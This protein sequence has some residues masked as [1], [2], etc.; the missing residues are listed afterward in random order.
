MIALADCNNFYASC[1][2]SIRPELEGKPIVVLSNN[3]GC[4]IAR[5]NESK[6]LGYKMGAPYFKVREQLLRDQ[7]HV[8]SG[9]IPFY[10][11]VSEKI[12]NILESECNAMEV[13]SIDE[14]FMDF[15]DVAAPD[16]KAVLLKKRVFEQTRI[17]ISV[18]IAETKVLAKLASHI[19]KKHCHTGVFLLQG[20]DLVSRALSYYAVEELWGVGRRHAHFLH[21]K[22]IFQASQLAQANESWLRKHMKIGGVRLARELNGIPCFSLEE[23]RPSK[24]SIMT[25]RSFRREL[26]TFASLNEALSNFASSCAFKLRKQKTRAKKI[27]V[28]IQT[29]RFKSAVKKHSAYLEL[30]FPVATNDSINIVKGVYQLLDRMY[31]AECQYKRAGVIVSDIIPD[32]EVQLN[33]FSEQNIVKRAKLMKVYDA[34]NQKMGEGTLK[35]SV[36]GSD[37]KWA[38]NNEP[39]AFRN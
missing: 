30:E 37:R 1:E 31:D 22:G 23:H 38:R 9:N 12:M 16:E 6:A 17:P 27:A 29:N 3:D 24:K 14:A 39:I 26:E 7:V 32:Q 28:F 2:R 18:G 34:I 19:A 25:S 11:E 5:S 36:Q 10:R 35:L 13:Y 15:T 21:D 4:I 8:F 33:L 20:K